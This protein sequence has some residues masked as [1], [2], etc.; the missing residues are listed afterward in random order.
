M[1]AGGFRRGQG[2][3]NKVRDVAAER[4]VPGLG[5]LGKRSVYD[6]SCFPALWMGKLRLG[7]ENPSVPSLTLP[8]LGPQVVVS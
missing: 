1:R 8:Q 6:S 7:Q 4:A 3:P 5:Q 2:L